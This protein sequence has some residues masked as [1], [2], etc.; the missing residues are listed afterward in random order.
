M[1]DHKWK[2]I[3]I[4]GHK[5]DVLEPAE[6]L[7]ERAVLFMHGH[8]E[9]TLVDNPVFT[10][11]LGNRGLRTICP[12]G[13]KGWWLDRACEAFDSTRTPAA[14]VTDEILPWVAA[15]WNAAAPRVALL[16]VS[17]GG[18][19]VLQMA[20]P[21]GREF[22]VV[23]AISPIV[24]F[25][26][27]LGNGFPLD[28][29]FADAEEARQWN[30]TLNLNPLNWPRYQ[31]LFCDPTDIWLEG[32]ERLG[33]KLSAS[34]ILHERD[35]ETTGGGHTW[36]YFNKVAPKAIEYLAKK[37]QRVVDESV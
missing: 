16:G 13:G 15:N 29:M 18:Q 10:E 20:Y 6:P 12:H 7:T 5:A 19:G 35:F 2:Q 17:M 21:K 25:Y 32:C 31:H 24:D 9:Q 22:P 3:E 33:M 36:D 8:G 27:C 34:G 4:G 26:N 1:A 11:L 23:A 28:D 14:W 37:L 30:V